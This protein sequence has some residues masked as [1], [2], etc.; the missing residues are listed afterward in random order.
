[1][2][3]LKLLLAC[4]AVT[5]GGRGAVAADVRLGYL[6]LDGS[7]P[8][9]QAD[10]SAIFGSKLQS[11]TLRDVLE[12]FAY[13]SSSETGLSGIVLRLRD[14]QLSRAQ[15]D[16]LGAGITTMREAGLKVHVFS[17]IFGPAELMLASYADEIILQQGGMVSLP[18]TYMEE[19]FLAD[20]L[21]MIGIRAD[22][23]QIGDY[24]GASEMLMNTAPSPAWEENISQLLDGLHSTMTEQVRRGR[25]LSPEAIEEAMRDCF[26]ADGRTAM[27]H[28]LIDREL[29]RLALNEHL[30]SVHGGAF[31]WDRELSPRAEDRTSNYAQMSFF[32]AFSK[33]MEAFT[34]SAKRGPQRDTIAVVHIDGQIIDGNS[35]G[36]GLFGGSAVGSLTIRK[37]LAEI[38]NEPRIKGVVVRIDSPGGSAI[39]SE[40]IWQGLRRVAAKKP[41]WVSVGSMAAS[42]GYYIAVA[43]ERV[44][45]NP[46][47]IVG[48]IGVVGGKLAMGG[49]YEKLHVNV[50]SRSRG[51]NSGLFGSLEPWSNEERMRIRQKMQE[52]YDLFVGRVL[53]G[54][55]GINIGQT[56]EGRLFVGQRA[57]D[58]RMAD[59]I[60]GINDAIADLA[61][62]LRLAESSYDVMDYPAPRSLEELIQEMFGGRASAPGGTGRL[63]ELA[64]VAEAVLGPKAWSSVR[65]AL[66]AALQLRTEPVLLLSPR[67]LMIY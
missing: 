40:I 58:L 37:A 54:R 64:A 15:I 52:T 65:A 61:T 21:G 60:G 3:W 39:A 47:S 16:E 27:R 5:L 25:G 43:G 18:G 31:S 63:H 33:V 53:Q 35:T 4:A 56:A 66:S 45:L 2:R 10:G 32:E 1:M 50:V 8:E 48:S 44:Y 49:L 30:R 42:G 62:E 36:G 14:L 51:P 29:D 11:E 20:A 17:E 67:V 12:K 38:E 55:E 9:R 19:I 24:K 59:A 23:V 7:I 26:M 6:A 57:V 41:V 46:S 22:F 13:A 28:K 34:G